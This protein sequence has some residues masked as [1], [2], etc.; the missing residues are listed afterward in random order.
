MKAPRRCYRRPESGLI[1][2]NVMALSGRSS[3]RMEACFWESLSDE[4][5]RR[6]VNQSELVRE[7]ER[8]LPDLPRTSAVRVWLLTRLRERAEA[9]ERAPSAADASAVIAPL[10]AAALPHTPNAG[11]CDAAAPAP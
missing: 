9:A 2:R 3:L 6:G 5:A 4:S 8:A 1:N 7:I 11:A 10:S